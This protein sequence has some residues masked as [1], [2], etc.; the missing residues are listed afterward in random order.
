LDDGCKI[1]PELSGAKAL[2][3][4]TKVEFGSLESVLTNALLLTEPF[5]ARRRVTRR[6]RN[7]INE[8]IGEKS[9]VAYRQCSAG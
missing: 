3:S 9:L 2:L 1:I 7:G 5:N 8:S 4:A 6:L